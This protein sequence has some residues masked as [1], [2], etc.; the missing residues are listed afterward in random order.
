M[1][2][3]GFD[4]E[5]LQKRRAEGKVKLVNWN[6]EP[7]VVVKAGSKPA[8]RRVTAS[9]VAAGYAP[10][11]GLC[12]GMGLPEPIPEYEYHPTRKWRLDYAWP[13]SKLALEIEGGIWTEGRHTR[14]QGAMNDLE[15][16]SEAAILG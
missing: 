6:G 15:K 7:T 10:L 12:R 4:E 5:W 8:D 2:W 3:T 13:L 9:A 14:G 16:Y 1:A 11:I